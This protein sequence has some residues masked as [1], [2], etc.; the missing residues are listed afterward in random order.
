MKLRTFPLRKPFSC[1]F[2]RKRNRHSS[3]ECA[4]MPRDHEDLICWQLA[5]E[6]RQ[7]VIAHT[8]PG[9][10]AAR[11]LR[12]TSNIRDAI[13]SACRN[14]SEGFYK[15]RHTEM[16]PFY[17]TAQGSLGETKDCI[18]DGRQRGYF[19]AEA[20]RA[21]AQLCRRAM[22]A[23]LKFLKSLRRKEPE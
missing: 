16:R 17:N 23:N 18:R 22:N 2:A 5:D 7:L 13:A 15:Y 4:G 14:Q 1:E 9:T 3:C 6:L 12:F 10:P 8:K 20:A 19:P 21:M 11:D